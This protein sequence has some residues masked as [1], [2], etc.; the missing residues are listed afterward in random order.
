MSNWDTRAKIYDY[1]EASDLRRGPYKS[2]L[3]QRAKGR[4]LLIGVGT[5]VDL[6]HF[7]YGTEIVAIDISPAMLARARKRSVGLR[8]NI[9]LVQTDALNLGFEDNC[10]DTVVTSCT[11]CS[12]SDPVKTFTE[13]RRV[14]KPGGKLLMFEHVRSLNPIFGLV[15]DLM[16]LYTKR[17]GTY[18]NRDTIGASKREGFRLLAV[19]SVFLDIILSIEADC[20]SPGCDVVR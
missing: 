15:L 6:K 18:M 2:T 10:F 11:L 16:T 5:G 4:S 20:P 3:F 1:C 13:I 19:T 17:L 9:A 14:L 8:R 12:V 7:A